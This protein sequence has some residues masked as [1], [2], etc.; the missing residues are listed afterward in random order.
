MR[1]FVLRDGKHS[2]IVLAIL[3]TLEPIEMLFE[4]IVNSKRYEKEIEMFRIT[5]N[6]FGIV[7]DTML[8]KSHNEVTGT[9]THSYHINGPDLV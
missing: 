7:T 3:K 5:T 6:E 9:I 2:E 8:L 4:T 1:Y